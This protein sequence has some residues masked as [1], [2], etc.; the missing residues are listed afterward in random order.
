[1]KN[2]S[3]RVTINLMIS[4]ALYLSAMS[5]DLTITALVGALLSGNKIFAT[6]PIAL[7]SILSVVVAPQ[8]PRIANLIGLKLVLQIGGFIAAIGGICSWYS[9]NVHSFIFLCIGTSCVGIYQAV[10][11]YYRYVASDV[12]RGHEVKSIS[13]I[14][15]AGVLAAIIG[16]M[17]ATWASDTFNPL[18]SGAYLVVS[19]LGLTAVISNSFLPKVAVDET[20]QSS[21]QNTN[22]S[23]IKISLFSL[24]KRSAFRNG[25]LILICSCFS[26]ALIM[27][28]AP[29]I[30]QSVLHNTPAQRMVGMQLHMVGMYLPVFILLFVSKYIPIKIQILI[31]LTVG[32][33]AAFASAFTVNNFSVTL[34]LLLIGICWSLC[35]TSGSALLTK[36]YTPEERQSARG[37]G[38]LF[39]VLGLA[40]GG[41][42]AGPFSK[43]VTWNDQM[44]IVLILILISLLMIIF[45]WKRI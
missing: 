39:P 11:N 36:S 31:G 30:M 15:S 10:A 41:L 34:T 26:M 19:V 27:S 13:L 8:I 16:P 9:L 35:Y 3:K 32:F 18:Y 6:L 12:S 44:I 22:D 33:F 25:V 5:I 23:Q 24:L 37:K 43:W 20:I 7:I 29:I 45:D 21:K 40:I 4:Q 38:E 17:L 28:G 2:D 42:L 14:M 1:M